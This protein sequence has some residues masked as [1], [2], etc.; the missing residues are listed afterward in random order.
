MRWVK[1]LEYLF[2]PE[3]TSHGYSRRRFLSAALGLAGLSL[4][5]SQMGMACS[6]PLN[7][8]DS[9]DPQ[10][11]I[12]G[13]RLAVEGYAT[14]RSYV[15]GERVTLGLSAQSRT[16]SIV[17]IQRL[18]ATVQPVWSSPVWGH[19]KPIPADASEHG[20]RW[21][22]GEGGDLAFDVPGEWPTGFYRVAMSAPSSASRQ[23]PGEAFFVVRSPHPGRDSKILLILS[24][25]TYAAYNNFGARR[26]PEAANTNGSFYDQARQAS[27]HRPLPL[28]FLSPYDCR[29]GGEP[30]RQQRYAGWGK[31]E[32]PFV[33]WAER[34]GIALDYATNEDLERYPDLLKSYRLVISVGHDE[35][36]SMGMRDVFDSYIRNGGNAA[37]FSGNV[38]YR[39]V[40][41]D[42]PASQMALVGEMDGEAL[43]SHRHG[44]NRPENRLTGVSFCYGAL[45]PNPIPYT[46]YQPHHWVFEGLWPAGGKPEQ[47]PHVGS[48]GYE[49]DGCDI[50]WVHGVPIA[51]HRDGTPESFEILGLAS[52]RMPDYEAVVHSKAL[53]GLE[54]GFTPWGKDLRQGAAVLGLWSQG[55]TVFTVGCTEWSRHLGDPLVARITRNV[56]TRLSA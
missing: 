5:R 6:L 49:C 38:C 56:L 46:I 45:N 41:L 17:A 42:V 52:G 7:L 16:R 51:S 26:V 29:S 48:I 39:Q 53:F 12:D 18:G 27:F 8:A 9:C 21:E 10:A 32:L 14:Q 23:R 30:S 35:Y 13:G 47:F 19:P 22:S 3:M 1:E 37:F 11:W 31:W 33:Q 4:A 36:W 34:E 50:E 28:G 54:H 43:W 55:G 15:Q 24:T 40:L 44:P 20:C 25:N 2:H